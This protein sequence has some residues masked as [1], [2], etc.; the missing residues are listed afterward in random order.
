MAYLPKSK[1]KIKSASENKLIYA[2]SRLP[3]I[4]QYIESNTGKLYAGTN[5]LILG[6][7]LKIKPQ[8]TIS[9]NW[10]SSKTV[11]VQIHNVLKPSINAFISNTRL[12]KGSKPIPTEKHYE[13][14][15]YQR[16]FT[17]RI[18]NYEYKEINEKT[19]NSISSKEN[20]YD[21][22]LNEV[23]KL[24]WHLVGN[25]FKKNTTSIKITTRTFPGIINLFPLINEFYREDPT[26][27]LQNNLNTIGKELYYDDGKEY[28]GLYHIHPKKGPMVGAQHIL[29][30]HTKLYYLNQLP[31]V[32]GFEY[33]DF[34][35]S[36]SNPDDLLIID[37]RPI[38][39]E[40][41]ASVK[42]KQ[43]PPITTRPS[44]GR[45]TR[46]STSGGG[47]GGY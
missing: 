21:Y 47:G 13:K 34:V 2:E 35:N 45:N 7:E 38:R 8:Q 11:D 39:N 6:K 25:V 30:N 10:T 22:K 3:F 40:M 36:L 18:N 41:A 16:Y 12:I 9:D 33:E 19:Y 32:M 42:V 14:G 26:P 31:K 4:G 17:K 27:T 20:T 15:Y 29:L 43:N 23:G 28:I 46:E 1:I 44:T 24:N 5:N 37:K